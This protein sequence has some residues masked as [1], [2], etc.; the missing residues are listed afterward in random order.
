MQEVEMESVA[1]SWSA[2]SSE[3]LVRWKG[4]LFVFPSSAL[5]TE[6]N[7]LARKWEIRYQ[8]TMQVKN[9]IDP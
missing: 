9:P 8:K 7:T 4:V 6:H 1:F 5:N 2:F 3:M